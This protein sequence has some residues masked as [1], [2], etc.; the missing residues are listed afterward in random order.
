M[1][2][3]FLLRLRGMVA[4][5]CFLSAFVVAGCNDDDVDSSLVFSK[6][7]L[8]LEA[9]GDTALVEV[10]A[11]TDWSAE[12]QADWCVAE[13]GEGGKL[14]IRVTP[15]DDIYERGTA[16]KV[17]CGDNIV[18]LAVRQKPMEFEILDG[19]KTLDFN[20][21][22][23]EDVLKIRTNMTW[24]VEIVDSTGWLQVA[25]TV[26]AGDAELVFKTTDNSKAKRRSTTVRLRYGIRSM[27]VTASQEGGLRG[28]GDVKKH[29]GEREVDK[30][31]NLIFLGDGF[32]SEDLASDIGVFDQAVE[33]A[34]DALFSVE[35]YKTYKEYFNVYSIACESKEREI[36]GS[37]KTALMTS[38]DENGLISGA[39]WK[40]F[41]YAGKILGMT[42]DILKTNTV[43]VVL[44]NDGRYGGTTYWYGNPAEDDHDYRA[45]SYVP[46]NRD[47]QLPGGFTNIFLHE[48]GGH[49]IGKLGDEWSTDRVFTRDDWTLIKACRDK[50]LYLSNLAIPISKAVITSMPNNVN[51]WPFL[52]YVPNVIATNYSDVYKPAGG[53]YG[54]VCGTV[55]YTYVYHC[56]EKSCMID[57]VPYFN[58][59]CRH[60]I[61]QWLLLRLNEYENTPMGKYNCGLYFFEHDRY[62]VPGDYSVSDRP[63]LPM[64]RWVNMPQ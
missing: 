4:I 39:N 41:D 42:D 18:R 20:K 2:T 14:L 37:S 22:V 34:C 49:A 43:V 5:G 17:T 44:V 16:V 50:K 8:L 63:P 19:K 33:E 59:V 29:Y 45:I 24:K 1:I 36:S 38:I 28:D 51:V 27:K 31:F 25:D 23:G 11:G 47:E 62:E 57:H 32:T 46:L 7:N 53:G 30:G 52:G 40:T 12:S 15:S 61:V 48:V 60:N 56:E 6:D 64:P 21:T 26:G 9:A 10:A 35:P 55:N 54:C 13:K 3:R 58:L